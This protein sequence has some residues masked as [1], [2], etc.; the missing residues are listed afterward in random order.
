[1]SR[2]SDW[3]SRL[4]MV[5][6]PLF[7]SSAIDSLG[8]HY[9]M[10]DGRGA[11]FACSTVETADVR[12]EDSRNWQ[13]SADLAHHV[14]ITPSQVEVRSGRDPAPRKFQLNSVE[15][16]LEAFLTY[17]DGSR[18]AAL[19]DV[20]SFLVEEFRN[21]WAANP[22]A[23]G[24]VALAAFLFA[25]CAAGQQDVSVLDDPTW[26]NN[27]ASDIGIDAGLVSAGFNDATIERARGMQAR[28]PLGLQLVPS[29]VLRH[30][31]GRLF[32]EAHAVLESVQL[33]LFGLAQISTSPNYSFA[34]A[35][36]TPVPIARLLAEWALCGWT[37][38]PSELTI[39]DFACGSGVFLA[40]SLRALE[41]IG[42]QGTV[43]LIGRDK[44]AQAISMA[45]VAIR[46][47]QR[48]ITTMQISLDIREADALQAE[49]PKADI[50]LMNPPF[51]S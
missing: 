1:M 45:K 39:G 14:L 11:S 32:Q 49:W 51:R 43:R 25:L 3:A 24:Q 28:A 4:G 10:L 41:R 15:N 38:L 9:A 5:I 50:I 21:I 7:A 22:S 47:V 34:A 44:S 31:A 40:E 26:R 48:D 19:P 23:E 35:Y 27:I 20:V 16:R 37:S 33:G 36:F 12:P 17:L 2:A 42:F 18:R 8:N 29:L 13:W 46:T 30:A 6:G